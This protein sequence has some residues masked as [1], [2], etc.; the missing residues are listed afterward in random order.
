M[1]KLDIINCRRRG[2]SFLIAADSQYLGELSSNEFN[3]NS[4]LNEYGPYGSK[5][6][7]TS[8]WNQYGMYGSEYS[9]YSPFNQYTQTPPFIYV[10]GVCVGRLSI[11]P[12][13]ANAISPSQLKQWIKKE[14]L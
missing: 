8:I 5:Y 4:I 3:V 1:E 10:H 9:S 2:E 13:V 11:N 14:N 12:Y 7:A 6:S